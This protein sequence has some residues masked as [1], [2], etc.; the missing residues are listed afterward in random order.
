ML[1]TAVRQL[2]KLSL[3]LLPVVHHGRGNTVSTAK[4]V[5]SVCLF[6]GHCQQMSRNMRSASIA[7]CARLSRAYDQT[8]NGGSIRGLP[9]ALGG[10]HTAPASSKAAIPISVRDAAP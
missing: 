4:A 6:V 5:W 10:T 1:Q 2:R 8:A 9:T 3:H 7:P